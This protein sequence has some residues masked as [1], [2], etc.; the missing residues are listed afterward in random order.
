MCAEK[1]TP[2]DRAWRKVLNGEELT[3]KDV[4]D[5]VEFCGCNLVTFLPLPFWSIG[6]KQ[7]EATLIKRARDHI[8]SNIASYYNGKGG[9][10]M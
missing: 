5:F 8:Y 3:D 6:L 2:E 10:C 7:S 9:W 1:E 4:K